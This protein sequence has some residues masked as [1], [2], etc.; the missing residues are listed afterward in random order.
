MSPGRIINSFSAARVFVKKLDAH[1]ARGTFRDGPC[2][3]ALRSIQLAHNYLSAHMVTGTR[4]IFTGFK[5]TRLNQ[6]AVQSVVLPP[7]GELAA[8]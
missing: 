7:N 3:T 4:L 8:K 1:N 6:P 2:S 5:N